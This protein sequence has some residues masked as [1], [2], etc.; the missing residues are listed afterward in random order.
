MKKTILLFS[1]LNLFLF[2][3]A[4]ISKT[5]NVTT[6]GTL[7][8]LL[9][10]SEKNTVTNLI[11]TGTIDARDFKFLC[12]NVSNLSILDLGSVQISG[13]TGS[14][15]TYINSTT[16]LANQL[17]GFAFCNS[18]N[19]VGKTSLTSV[20]LPA[21]TT[22][23]GESAF[24]SCTGLTSITIP[25]AVTKIEGYVF[26]NCKGLSAI[27]IPE[28]VNSLGN[29][30]F[31][32]CSANLTVSSANPNFIVEDGVLFNSS[33][34]TL[35]ECQYNK[36]GDYMI[37]SSVTTVSNNAFTDCA[38]ITSIIIPSSVVTINT[39]AFTSCT[40]LTT[41]TIPATL[42]NLG[43]YA[44][45]GCTGLTSIYSHI[46]SPSSLSFTLNPFLNVDKN[47]CKLYVPQGSTASYKSTTPWS[48]F[49]NIIEMTTTDNQT[50]A[51]KN[52]IRIYPNPA[53]ETLSISGITSASEL[54]IFDM[55]GRKV[56]SKQ[57]VNNE[58]ISVGSLVKGTYILRLITSIGMYEEKVIIKRFF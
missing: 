30:P 40:G 13:Y 42:T 50:L 43:W 3:Q 14:D 46:T 27:N 48:E 12:D 57:I 55:N 20:T 41:V 9:T 49:S 36:T 11:V 38:N 39:F 6:P 52:K 58:S 25:L 54:H 34:S 32:S 47:L 22:A 33:K 19:G 29:S 44:F 4:Q 28:N 23:I 53:I 15:G 37:P 51:G 2:S 1:L 56:I 21:T 5:I 24:S 31:R 16:Y 18:T 7:T 45:S 26:Y 17:P 8:Y 35:I 10:T